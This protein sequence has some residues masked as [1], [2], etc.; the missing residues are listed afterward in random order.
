[1]GHLNERGSSQQLC[2]LPG[3]VALVACHAEGLM[4]WLL[5]GWVGH[6]S[7][8]HLGASLG[9]AAWVILASRATWSTGAISGAHSVPMPLFHSYQVTVTALE[10]WVYPTALQSVSREV[11]ESALL[12]SFWSDF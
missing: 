6:G 2:L 12:A 7:L 11:Q 1:M 10:A 5:H 8:N 9:L 3:S 4:Q